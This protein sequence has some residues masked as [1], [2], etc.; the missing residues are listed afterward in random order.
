MSRG[1]EISAD[2]PCLQASGCGCAQGVSHGEHVTGLGGG[3]DQLQRDGGVL[4]ER[5]A[6]LGRPGKADT[7]HPEIGKQSVGVLVRADLGHGGDEV[8]DG[9]LGQYRVR[10]RVLNEISGA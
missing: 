8:G 10:Q 7:E 4:R 6:V 9:G 1:E 5:G 3:L 2:Q